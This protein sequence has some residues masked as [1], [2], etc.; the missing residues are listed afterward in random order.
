[1]RSSPDFSSFSANGPDELCLLAGPDKN[2]RILLVP[3]LFDEMNRMR[4]MLV[5]LMS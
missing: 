5:D 3:P 1:M 4:R 2:L